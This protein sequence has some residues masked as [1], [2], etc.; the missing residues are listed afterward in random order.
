MRSQLRAH[1]A[2]LKFGARMKKQKKMSGRNVAIGMFAAVP[3]IIAG[4]VAWNRFRNHDDEFGDDD[5][6]VEDPRFIYEG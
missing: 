3:A 4:A 1:S 6:V 5:S 2:Q